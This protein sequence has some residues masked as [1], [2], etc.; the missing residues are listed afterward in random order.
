MPPNNEQQH[1]QHQ[2]THVPFARVLFQG[3]LISLISSQGTLLYSTI[4]GD[5]LFGSLSAAIGH[6]ILEFLR[7]SEASDL[8]LSY[9]LDSQLDKLGIINQTIFE[10]R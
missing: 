3:T 4:K 6:N 5:I 9:F 2:M 10:T 8:L 7:V 1:Q